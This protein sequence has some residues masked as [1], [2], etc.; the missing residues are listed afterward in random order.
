MKLK[1]LIMFSAAALAFA[2]CS[3]DEDFTGNDGTFDGPGAVSVKITTADLTRMAGGAT[4]GADGGKVDITGDLTVTLTGKKTETAATDDYQE[5][6]TIDAAKVNGDTKL[7]FWNIA[8][9]TKLTV[10]INGGVADYTAQGA[11]TLVDL[12]VA[13]GA[14]KIPAYGET[15]DFTKTDASSSPVLNNDNDTTED[16]TE[17]GAVSGDEDKEY[18]LYS[19]TV[20]MAIPVARLEVSNIMHVKHE[21]EETCQY[22]TLVANGAYLDVLTTVGSKYN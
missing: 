21:G 5:T 2:A 6:I 22:K 13:E 20:T 9:P 16:G 1:S 10:S 14:A 7:T 15:T 18:Q 17:Q 8:V 12:Q 4:S 19:A 3:N 11:P